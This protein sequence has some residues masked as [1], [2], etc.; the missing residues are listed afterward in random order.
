[1]PASLRLLTRLMDTEPPTAT[2]T[3]PTATL[4]ATVMLLIAP[5]KREDTCTCPPLTRPSVSRIS[6]FT[7]CEREMPS[8]APPT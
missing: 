2:A 6:A 4:P 5:S 7:E 8:G 1:M 3:V